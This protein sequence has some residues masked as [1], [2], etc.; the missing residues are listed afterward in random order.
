M[1]TITYLYIPDQAVWVITSDTAACPTAI[2]SGV[3]LRVRIEVLA[4]GTTI[5][6][7]VQLEGDN[8]TTEFLEIDVFATLVGASAEY[9]NRLNPSGSP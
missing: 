5:N 6:Y 9:E 2:R 4:T 8:G 7:D 3:V 1:A